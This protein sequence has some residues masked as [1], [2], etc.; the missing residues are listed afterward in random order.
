MDLLIQQ[1]TNQHTCEN[2]D[3]DQG[4]YLQGLLSGVDW[5]LVAQVDPNALIYCV[6]L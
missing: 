1:E 6:Q 2:R 4:P 5:F 3:K